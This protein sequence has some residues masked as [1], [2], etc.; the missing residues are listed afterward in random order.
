MT[1]ITCLKRKSRPKVHVKVCETCTRR[2]RCQSFQLF[3]N[4]PLFL[5]DDLRDLA[6]LGGSAQ[7][8]RRRQ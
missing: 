7:N 5:S 8:R 4:P 1:Y 3:R 2:N 6:V